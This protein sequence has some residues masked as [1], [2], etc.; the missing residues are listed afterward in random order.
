MKPASIIFLVLSIILIITGYVSCEMAKGMA[1]TEGISLYNDSVDDDGNR[2]NT[3][4][5]NSN[6]YDRIEVNITKAK[7]Y[8]MI[9]DEE[10][11]VLK[12]Y[13]EGS[14]TGS[15]SGVSYIITDNQSALDMIT[16]GNFNLSFS[17]I[18]HYWHDRDILSREKEV[19][20]YTTEA[21][22]VN[23]IDIV[24]GEGTLTIDKYKAAFDVMAEVNSGEVLIRGSEAAAFN[25]TGADC[26]LM[27]EDSSAA[28]FHADIKNGS[29]NL[30][31]TEAS[32]L[33]KL[34]IAEI[35]DV[36]VELGGLESEYII[37]AYA[38][39][40]VTINGSNKGTQYPPEKTEG[41][42]EGQ[43]GA[44]GTE[45]STGTKTLDIHVT[46]GTVSIK[47]KK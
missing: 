30:K 2:V 7:V 10:K 21:T 24:L 5:F 31:N 28:R 23:G 1:Q 36:K 25:I 43:E 20:I 14:F 6:E 12:N 17:G 4:H 3:I 8:L 39:K 41:E 16:S 42:G 32:A 18:R 44:E 13:T 45:E 46:S 38:S 34:N 40:N 11:V 15:A 26:K 47:T 35:G 29:V 33:T 22:A 37:T 19:Y 27:A 9:G